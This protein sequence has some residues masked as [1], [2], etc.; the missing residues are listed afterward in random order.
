[1]TSSGSGIPQEAGNGAD[2]LD[3]TLNM[4]ASNLRDAMPIPV[5][6]AGG[7]RNLILSGQLRPGERIVELK[8][9]R[10]LGIGQPTAREALLILETEGL[11]QRSPNRGCSVTSLTLKQ[12]DQIYCVRVEL[13][14]LAAELAV[15]NAKNWDRK[16]LEQAQAGLRKAAT[17]GNIE[18]WHR[19]DL[20]FHRTLWRLADNPFL[21]KALSQISIPFFAFAELVFMQTHPRDLVQQAEQHQV[22][23][24]AILSGNRKEARRVTRKVLTGFWEVWRKLANPPPR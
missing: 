21:E 1:M 14:P 4:V 9:A 6:V 11:V 20:E 15:G 2:L 19:R 5:Q 22:F 16:V 23:V 18:L 3:N 7:L 17:S 8:I 12:I 13:E 24:S 10:Q